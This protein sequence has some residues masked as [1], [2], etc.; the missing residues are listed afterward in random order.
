MY[1]YSVNTKKQ[2]TLNNLGI[3]ALNPMQEAMEKAVLKNKEILLLAPTGSGKT[4]GF[5]FPIFNQLK[6][7]ITGVQC[8]ILTPTRE[9]ALQI[10]QVWKK[11]G[12]GF[13]VNVCYGGHSMTTEIQ[14]LSSPPSILISTPG[15]LIDHI[16]KDTFSTDNLETLVLDEFDKSLEMGFHDQMQFIIDNLTNLNQRI[17]VSATS[18][19]QIPEFANVQNPFILDYT[20]NE[21]SYE[22]LTLKKVVSYEKDKI[23]TLFQLLCSF[24]SE[25]ALVFCNHRDAV[26]RVSAMLFQKGIFNT[27]YHGGLDQEQREK[28]L[29]Q[30]RNGSANYLI[31]TDVAARGLDIPEMKHVVHYHMPLKSHEFIHRNGRTARMKSEG[32]AY[33]ILTEDEKQPNYVEENIQ[34]LILSSRNPL[35]NPPTFATIYISGGKKNK[36]NKIDIV[37]FLIQKGK[38]EKSD[39]GLIEVKDFA[40]FVAIQKDKVERLFLEIK[41]EKIKGKKYKIDYMN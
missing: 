27:F 30:F 32:T 9:L 20:Q 10:E 31:T 26:E 25:A 16:E 1:L 13:K 36:L 12:T 41:N 6:S 22:N 29:I 4:L 39:I 38:I 40:S 19:I 11:M 24:N 37:G 2:Q 35:P 23:E 14:N 21:D 3:E 33:I 34:E 28:A 7:N 8:L 17:L 18:N 5:L 15:R